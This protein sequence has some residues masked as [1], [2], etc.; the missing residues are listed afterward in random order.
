[1]LL[2]GSVVS[3][4]L[5]HETRAASAPA[6]ALENQTGLLEELQGLVAQ[7]HAQRQDYYEQ[8]SQK[9]AELQEARENARVLEA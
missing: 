1:V 8:K 7:F 3:C 2:L 9:Q 6:G 4:L 5:A